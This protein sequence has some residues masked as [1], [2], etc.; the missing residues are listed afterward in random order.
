MI[1]AMQVITSANVVM[2]LRKLTITI[3]GKLQKQ[4]MHYCATS[5]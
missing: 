5:N 3:H 2:Y 4:L 1:Y